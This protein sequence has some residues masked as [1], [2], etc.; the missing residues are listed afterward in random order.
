MEEVKFKFPLG[1]KLVDIVSGFEGIA[2]ARIQYLNGCLQY[3]VKPKIKLS[4]PEKMP[5]GI[6]IDE[7]QLKMVEEKAIHVEKRSTGG[8]QQDTPRG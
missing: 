3:C 1:C 8:P 4:E 5:D 6:Y 2:V 7:S